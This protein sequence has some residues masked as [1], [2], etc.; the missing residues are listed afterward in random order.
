VS[1]VTVASNANAEKAARLLAEPKYVPSFWRL[2]LSGHCSHVANY[3]STGFP[4]IDGK[5]PKQGNTVLMAAIKKGDAD[6][7]ETL[8]RFNASAQVQNEFGDSPIHFCWRFWDRAPDRKPVDLTGDNDVDKVSVLDKVSELET[9]ETRK[10]E[11]GATTIRLLKLLLS[12]GAE[13]NVRDGSGGTALHDAARRYVQ[14]ARE[15]RRRARTSAPRANIGAAREHHISA[16]R[17]SLRSLF[18]PPLARCFARSRRGPIQAVKMLLQFGA[19]SEMRNDSGQ[20]AGF[21]A[22]QQKQQE[23]EQLLRIWPALVDPHK[24]AEFLAEWRSFLDDV[25]IPIVVPS[26]SARRVLDDLTIAEHQDTLKRWK[27]PGMPVVDEVVTGP[28]DVPLQAEATIDDKKKKL[29]EEKK[30]RAIKGKAKNADYARVQ[31]F[32]NE[33]KKKIEDPNLSD[34][35]RRV[36]RANELVAEK[37]AGAAAPKR[38]PKDFNTLEVPLDYYLQGKVTGGFI[39]RK[40]AANS[41]KLSKAELVGVGAKKKK[42]E[43]EKRRLYSTCARRKSANVL[44]PLISLALAALAQGTHSPRREPR[45]ATTTSAS[46]G[47]MNGLPTRATTGDGA[48]QCKCGTTGRT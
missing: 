12:H 44:P 10:Q 9:R 36:M 1:A 38:L 11:Q 4:H 6:M 5:E 33:G 7:V 29:L 32:V 46:G 25:D 19:D 40:D 31:K 20:T 26:A 21:V 27:R 41:K 45:T 3:L 22:K 24:K 14:A 13:A 34:R 16:A 37:E 42:L 43:E 47:T 17:R 15:G 48:P 18:L 30:G 8:L 28:L 39:E 35:D 23:A 2:V